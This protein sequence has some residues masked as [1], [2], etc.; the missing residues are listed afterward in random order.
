MTGWREFLG[1]RGPLG[2]AWVLVAGVFGAG[3]AAGERPAA[4]AAAPTA[5]AEQASPE[6]IARVFEV[7]RVNSDFGPLVGLRFTVD[8]DGRRV[9]VSSWLATLARRIPDAYFAQLLTL[10]PLPGP[11]AGEREATVRRGRR[12]VRVRLRPADADADAEDAEAFEV[13]LTLFDGSGR[14]RTIRRVAAPEEGRTEV[15]TGRDFEVTPS[16]YL[17]WF[18]EAGGPEERERLYRRLRARTIFLA[19]ALS[20]PA[21]AARGDDPRPLPVRL[22]P[23]DEPRL[24]ELDSPL[25]GA[26]SGILRLSVRVDEDGAPRDPQILE[27]TFPE[28][29]P[30][31]LGIVSGWRFPQA[32]GREGRLD[33]RLGSPAGSGPT[34]G[35][36]G[37]PT[38]G[39]TGGPTGLP[40]GGPS[41][42]GSPFGGLPGVWYKR[43]FPETR[44]A[45]PLPAPF[46]VRGRGRAGR[47]GAGR[48]GDAPLPARTREERP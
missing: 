48:R 31:A 3:G 33:L 24:L 16:D 39:P 8:T 1:C 44:A 43:G 41:E 9:P 2:G 21:P 37:G 19:L 47:P 46:V 30:R 23:P 27:S 7:R 34:G 36:T 25:V 15:F 14:E 20:R 22:R 28:V 10:R 29:A 42:P 40:T 26:A 4:P 18:R 45:S 12:G 38:R 5:T 17:S 11:I 32:A 13:A 6:L 35:P